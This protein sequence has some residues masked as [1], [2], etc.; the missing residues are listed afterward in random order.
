M[1]WQYFSTHSSLGDPS[2]ETTGPSRRAGSIAIFVSRLKLKP[3]T[4]HEVEA[5]GDNPEAKKFSMCTE[6]ETEE[7]MK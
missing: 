3:Q 7:A 6:D 4:V 1:N 2:K 5:E